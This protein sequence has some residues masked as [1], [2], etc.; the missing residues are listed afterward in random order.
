MSRIGIVPLLSTSMSAQAQYPTHPAREEQPS[1]GLFATGQP[2][3][4]RVPLPPCSNLLGFPKDI[5]SQLESRAAN[6]AYEAAVY[7]VCWEGSA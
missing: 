1:I 4:H 3:P 7:L 6:A 5:A 2:I